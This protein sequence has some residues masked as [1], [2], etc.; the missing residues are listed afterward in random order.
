[1]AKVEMSME[2]FLQL[3]QMA[4]SG[5]GGD[6]SSCPHLNT[7]PLPGNKKKRS[8]KKSSS[9]N[10]MSKALKEATAKGKLKSGAW[11]KGWNQSRVMKEAHR[12]KKKM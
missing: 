9:D 1:M 12:L 4:T 3:Q 6:C 8:R 10:K 11:K 5:G 2:E 7:D